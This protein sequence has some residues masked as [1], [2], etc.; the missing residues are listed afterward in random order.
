GR[1]TLHRQWFDM[2]LCPFVQIGDRQLAA[3]CSKRLGA[4]PCDR[5]VIGYSNDESLAPFQSH[6]GF[7]KYGN[8]HD[9]LS[10]FE[11]KCRF[12]S[13]DTVCCAIINPSSV[14]TM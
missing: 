7:W 14:G 4:S 10:R 12:H 5:L 3:Q 11:L 2:L 1:L 13:N 6:F 8:R 9:A